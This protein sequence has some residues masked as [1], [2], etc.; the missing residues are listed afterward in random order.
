MVLFQHDIKHLCEFWDISKKDEKFLDDWRFYVTTGQKKYWPANRKLR[1]QQLAIDHE[2]FIRLLAEDGYDDNAVFDGKWSA[3]KKYL[4]TS[5]WPSAIIILRCSEFFHLNILQT[6]ILC[7]K[8]SFEKE[9]LNLPDTNIDNV[10]KMLFANETIDQ[11]TDFYLSDID[12]IKF[13]LDLRDFRDFEDMYNLLKE[14]YPTIVDLDSFR[15]LIKKILVEKIHL[16]SIFSKKTREFQGRWDYLDIRKQGEL[17]EKSAFIV[18]KIQWADRKLELADKVD[19][20][21]RLLEDYGI[22]VKEWSKNVELPY[23][24]FIETNKI[25]EKLN[26]VTTSFNNEADTRLKDDGFSVEKSLIRLDVKNITST[27]D[28]NIRQLYADSIVGSA[29]PLFDSIASGGSILSFSGQPV[30]ELLKV[31]SIPDSVFPGN[32]LKEKIYNARQEIE[33]LDKVIDLV[34]SQVKLIGKSQHFRTV[35]LHAGNTEYYRNQFL[36]IALENIQTAKNLCRFENGNTTISI[37]SEEIDVLNKK[38][39]AE[40]EKF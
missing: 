1:Q 39:L 38:I 24:Y 12:R 25:I 26:N 14:F 34:K 11:V 5:G 2:N 29:L 3:V 4:E 35:K 13:K 27:L 15:E 40:V 33:M 7:L 23:N 32:V 6:V 19:E 16:E 28:S 22:M 21:N 10:A 36:T 31:S 18:L 9:I 30:D 37:S 8:T 20:L 17:R